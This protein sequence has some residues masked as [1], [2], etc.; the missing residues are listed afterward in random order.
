LAVSCIT[1]A[2][3][4]QAETLKDE[5]YTSPMNFGLPAL[6]IKTLQASNEVEIIIKP[7][8]LSSPVGGGSIEQKKKLSELFDLEKL[9]SLILTLPIN[10]CIAKTM[11]NAQ[12][13]LFECGIF[14][15]SI[16]TVTIQGAVTN[17]HGKI[18][19]VSSKKMNVNFFVVE[20]LHL[21]R[22]SVHLSENFLEVNVLGEI[23]IEGNEKMR[24]HLKKSHVKSV[25]Q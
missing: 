15:N 18:L 5:R 14:R 12:T 20:L 6:E 17:Y 8:V 19:S 2:A 25:N 9:N 11:T 10:A 24:L 22:E 4:A 21:N 3:H 16:E 1:I 23:Q 7:A 13:Q